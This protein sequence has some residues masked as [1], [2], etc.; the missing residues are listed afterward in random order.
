MKINKKRDRSRE[1]LRVSKSTDWINNEMIKKILTGDY[2]FWEFFINIENEKDIE[3]LDKLIDQFKVEKIGNALGKFGY[4]LVKKDMLS[5]FFEEAKRND[6]EGFDGYECVEKIIGVVLEKNK[7]TE[8]FGVNIFEL[9]EDEE[10]NIRNVERLYYRT[11]LR[12]S[13]VRHILEEDMKK[14]IVKALMK[15]L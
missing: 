15:G 4:H 12:G 8:R 5:A 13:E 10:L 9:R 3:Y 14:G 11:Y 2:A 7:I 6:E 1:I